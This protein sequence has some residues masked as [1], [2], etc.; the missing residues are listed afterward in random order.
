MNF[1]GIYLFSS[2]VPEK[3]LEKSPEKCLEKFPEKSPEKSPEESPEKSPDIFFP[4]ISKLVSENLQVSER[5]PDGICTECPP[6]I[7]F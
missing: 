1:I 4:G 7:C 3:C 6:V 2:Y 5:Y